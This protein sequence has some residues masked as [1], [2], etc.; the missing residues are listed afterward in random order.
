[1]SLQ[2][3]V[4]SGMKVILGKPMKERDRHKT[5]FTGLFFFLLDYFSFSRK[6]KIIQWSVVKRRESETEIGY[7]LEI[8]PITN[9]IAI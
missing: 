3:L 1:M 8:G 2:Y 5:Y 9:R 7:F 4:S 6:K